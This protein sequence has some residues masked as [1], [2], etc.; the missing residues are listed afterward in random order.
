MKLFLFLFFLIPLGVFGQSLDNWVIGSGGEFSPGSKIQLSWTLGELNTSSIKTR[1]GLITEGF[2]Q[3]YIV[4]PELKYKSTSDVLDVFVFPN[5][6]ADWVQV[7]FADSKA[8]DFDIFVHDAKGKLL[9]FQQ[10]KNTIQTE[11]S[12]ESLPAAIYM[13]SIQV[14][15]NRI[16]LP[17]SFQIIKL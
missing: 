4:L 16:S 8:R 2:Q 13:V 9:Q 17:Y 10:F 1:N 15:D 6:T 7:N 3:S 11:L 12:L 5:P 14:K